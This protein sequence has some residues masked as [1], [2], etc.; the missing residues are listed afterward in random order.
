MEFNQASTGRM[1]TDHRAYW[2][3]AAATHSF[4]HPMNLEWLAPLR[5]QARILD[6]GCGYG[7]TLQVLYEH[8]LRNGLGVDFSGGMIARGRA[9]HPHLDLRTIGALPLAEPDG[10]FDAVL[11][12]A[13]LTCIPRDEDQ[14]ALIAELRRLLKPGGLLYVSDYPLQTD[15]RNLARYQASEARHGVHGV[16]EREDGGV[17]R[18]HD[19]AWLRTLLSGFEEAACETVQ[20]TTMSGH[21]AESV[22]MLCRR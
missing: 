9:L 8:G 5:H 16:W 21:P 3:R 7:R 12:F 2:D 22:Q 6:Y 11:L 19:M 17:F 15:A 4:T 10:A 18:H 13:V 1:D 14:I 20:T